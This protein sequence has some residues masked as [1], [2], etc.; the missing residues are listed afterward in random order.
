MIK[1]RQPWYDESGKFSHFSYWGRM[2]NGA[3]ASPSQCNFAQPKD[4]EAFT[5][6]VDRDG[7]ELWDGDVVS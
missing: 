7:M 6:T 3:F 4:D 5:E 2:N 1:V